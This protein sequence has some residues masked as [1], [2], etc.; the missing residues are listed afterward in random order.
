M[1]NRFSKLFSSCFIFVPYLIFISIFLG[2]NAQADYIWNGD[3]TASGSAGTGAGTGIATGY[4]GTIVVSIEDLNDSNVEWLFPVYQPG[5][6][7]SEYGITAVTTLREE[8]GHQYKITFGAAVNNPLVS[9]SSLGNPSTANRFTF[10]S[11]MVNG[12]SSGGT[13][14]IL[15]QQ[16]GSPSSIPGTYVTSNG[17]NGSLTGVTFY[18]APEG[19]FVAKINANNV[20]E[21]VYTLS[22]PEVYMSILVGYDELASPPE[23][24]VLA[25]P[26][27]VIAD[28]SSTS[29]VT[30]QTFDQFGNQFHNG[31]D[32]IVI[33]TDF[34]AISST[35]DNLDGTYTATITSQTAGLATITATL[36]GI[37]ITGGSVQQVTF[38]TDP[39]IPQSIPSMGIWSIG[40]LIGLISFVGF[41]R[42]LNKYT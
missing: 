7:P 35:T 18:E 22:N 9:I 31:G 29:I 13:V 38:I 5:D 42:R 26:T 30:V 15:W 37:T 3:L 40:I 11:F 25:S 36:G 23:S 19:D 39:N 10:D 8:Q 14:D 2:A 12:I 33:S 20:T 21:I 24:T 16:N 32:N 1:F 4:A 6:F 27:T 41:R 28:G 34:G 17:A